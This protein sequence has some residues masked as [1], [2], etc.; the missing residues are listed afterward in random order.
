[1]HVFI[2]YLVTVLLCSRHGGWCW[3][4]L[5]CWKC[6]VFIAV[7]HVLPASMSYL[8]IYIIRH[9][10]SLGNT[11]SLPNTEANLILCKPYSTF[12]FT[13]NARG[14][15]IILDSASF[16]LQQYLDVKKTGNK[17]E[18][19]TNHTLGLMKNTYHA[20]ESSFWHVKHHCDRLPI[21]SL[22]VSFQPERYE[23]LFV[24]YGFLV[25]YMILHSDP[26]FKQN[27][28]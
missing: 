5:A 12:D 7:T 4:I 21:F 16:I 20:I 19:R 3:W 24:H 18:T 11:A 14:K 27:N 23:L 13:R 22:G 25:F 1:M 28:R 15:I 17:E 9:G 10:T 8:S 6:S 2:Q 26:D